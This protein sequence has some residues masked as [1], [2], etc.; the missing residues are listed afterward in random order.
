MRHNTLFPSLPTPFVFGHRGFN[1]LAIENTLLSFN[2]CYTKKVKGIEL[3]VH[4]C[5]SGHIV[6]IHDHNLTRLAQVDKR[7]EDLTYDELHELYIE[8][9]GKIPLLEEVFS[10]FNDNF[11][12]DIEL[13]VTTFGEQEIVEKTHAII[14]QFHL[15]E[16]VIVSS[17]NPIIIRRWN[18]KTNKSTHTGVIYSK[19]DEVPPYL[20]KGQGRFIAH[21]T[22]M[23]PHYELI[24]PSLVERY[25]SKGYKVVTWSVNKEEDVLRMIE[26]NVDGIISDDPVMVMYIIAG[27][28][29]KH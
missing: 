26:S 21:P 15:E 23:K 18:K 3:D 10:T 4:L 13:K 28:K 27:L 7:V 6:V 5:K 8:G 25:H 12:Y 1:A 20:H 9:T 19:H 14:S 29:E 16:H 22:I 11:Y 17:F 24:T 2:L